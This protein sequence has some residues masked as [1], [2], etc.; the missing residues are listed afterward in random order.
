MTMNAAHPVMSG[1]ARA[2]ARAHTRSQLRARVISALLVAPAVI[3]ILLAFI[4]PLVSM[5]FYAVN[6]P[7]VRFALPRSVE[8]IA[9]WDGKSEPD[10]TVFAALASDLR[11]HEDGNAIAEAGRRLNYEIPGFRTM[12]LKTARATRRSPDLTGKDAFVAIDPNWTDTAHWHA[13]K[14]ASSPY[15]AYY[16]LAALDLR[17]QDDGSIAQAPPEDRLFIATLARTMGISFS[18]TL[19]CLLIGYPLAHAIT[20][21]P[22]RFAGLMLGCILL[23]FWTSLLVRTSAWIVIL[24]KEGLI[25]KVLAFLGIISAPLEL[26]FNR[27]GLY[28]AMVHIL[29]PFMVLP[30]LSVMT[31]VSPSYMRASASLGAG[32][33]RSFLLV[34]LPLTLPGIG[35]G[36]LLTFIIAAGYYITPTLVG[37][38][39]DQMLSYF[40]AF[41]ANTTINWGMSAALGFVLLAC[42]M[43]LYVIMGKLIG[44][45][46]IAGIG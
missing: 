25:N 12:L 22:A 38:A 9:Q 33:V 34:Y 20:V 24:Q 26:V 30:V 39:S 13:I 23:P 2:Q 41:F 43:I 29:L 32:P 8:R 17:T 7:E 1:F 4:L 16:L 3:F 10:E 40:V 42:V 11:S 27:T 21:L 6:N 5:L 46:R 37:G 14:R 44:I 28:I 15:T 19:I 45:N 36:C 35:A 31:G 18:V